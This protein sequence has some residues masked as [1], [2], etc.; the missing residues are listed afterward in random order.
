MK[1]LATL[2]MAVF[3]PAL[4][5][6]SDNEDWNIKVQSTYIWQGKPPLRSP[7]AGPN[8]LSGSREKSYSFTGTAAL[9]LRLGTST[10]LYVD[11]EVAQGV[12]LSGLQGLAGFSNG[13]MAR[14]SGPN[15]TLYRARFFLRHVIGLTEETVPVESGMN[16]LA[17]SYAKSRWVVTV[18]NLSI[19]D[20]FDMNAYAHDP[21]TQF[22]NWALMSHAAYDYAA[23]SRGYSWGL[24]TEYHAE[25]WTVRAGRFIQPKE[26]NMLALDF[27]IGVHYGDQVEVEKRYDLG[28][29]R[30]GAVRLLAFRNRAVMSRYDEALALASFTGGAPDI[31]Q[32]RKGAHIKYGMGLNVEQRVTRE[33][34]IFGRAMWADGKTE[35]YAFTQAD[36]SASFG[37]SLTGNR[38]ARANDVIGIGFAQHWLSNA[39]RDLLAR[40]GQTFFLGDGALRYRPEQVF[41]AYYLF[42]LK[43]GAAISFDVQRI[44]NPGYNADRGPA[45]FYG[46]RVHL[47]N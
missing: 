44:A 12:P 36:R 16:Q 11:P 18:G 4:T 19:P 24:T 43:E 37:A 42:A 10:E 13:E 9:G 15:P 46:V 39:D 3:C 1:G 38:W 6:A 8:S 26:P 5:W 17:S 28:E 21:R 31:D 14:S 47:E 20:I 45:M 22:M 40:G 27:R 33:L 41:E 23:D 30:P 25:D 32:V 2:L 29:G 34:G 7:Y 35:T